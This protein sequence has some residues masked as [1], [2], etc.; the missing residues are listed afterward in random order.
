MTSTTTSTSSRAT[1]AAASAL[2]RSAGTATRRGPL[3]VGDG[4]TDELQADPGTGGD[5]L[6]T[7]EQYLGQCA[8]DIAA[9][10]QPDAHGRSLVGVEE[11]AGLVGGHLQTVQGA[12]TVTCPSARPTGWLSSAQQHRSPGP[13]HEA[14]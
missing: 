14:E 2:R 12:R 10:E 11:G 3:R 13:A 8:A 5:V 9:P 4:D 7:G 1:S 6:G